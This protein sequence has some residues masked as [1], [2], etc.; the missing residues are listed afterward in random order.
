MNI[1]KTFT[2]MRSFISVYMSVFFGTRWEF[3]N[4]Q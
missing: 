4:G 1:A 2:K 3:R